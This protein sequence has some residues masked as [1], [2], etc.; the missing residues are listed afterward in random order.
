MFQAMFLPIIRSTLLYLQYVVVSTQVAA[1]CQPEATWVDTTIY[2]KYSKV[3][4]MMGKNIAWNMYSRLEIKKI[5][6]YSA[7]CWLSS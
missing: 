4:L 6:L 2:C 5:N 1:S 7:S 3:L